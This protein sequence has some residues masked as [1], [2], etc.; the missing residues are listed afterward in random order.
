MTDIIL[1]LFLIAACA[2]CCWYW[3]RIE[4]A[5]R[6]EAEDNSASAEPV[7]DLESKK[8][9]VAAAM[10][11]INVQGA[12]DGDKD[13]ATM[14]FDYQGGHF[15]LE[16][17]SGNPDA[18]LVFPF[19]YSLSIKDV[20]ALRTF[21]NRINQSFTLARLV[22]SCN[23]QT[24][25]AD[26]H[27][28]SGFLV[29][30]R[31]AGAAVA[32][33]LNEM[34][35]CRNQVYGDIEEVKR[36]NRK[37]DYED[38][39]ESV[40]ISDY[41][42]NLMAESELQLAQWPAAK[43][44]GG[45]DRPRLGRVLGS[46]LDFDAS[47]IQSM[48]VMRGDG[49]TAVVATTPAADS[50]STDAEDAAKAA[51]QAIADFDLTTAMVADGR[52]MG[53]N[54]MIAVTYLANPKD[55]KPRLLTLSLSPDRATDEALYMR[56]TLTMEAPAV[57]PTFTLGSNETRATAR[58]FCIACDLVPEAHIAAKFSY[59]WKEAM[60][61]DCDDS[62]L[63]DDDRR[64]LNMLRQ[65]C[66]R[67]NAY[68]VYRGMQLF[69]QKRYAEALPR[70]RSAYDVVKMHV[71]PSDKVEA[72]NMLDLCYSI[73]VAYYVL[74]RYAQ[75]A[76]YLGLTVGL[77]NITYLKAYVNA[78]IME[79]DVRAD[80][81][82]SSELK[83]VGDE[84]EQERASDDDDDDSGYSDRAIQ[85][86]GYMA[87]LQCRKALLLASADR[88]DEAEELLHQVVNS[89]D[90]KQAVDTLAMVRRMR[91]ARDRR[92]GDDKQA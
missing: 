13:E 5:H 67:S 56:A 32:S 34:F 22:Y 37:A 29:T 73:G 61:D 91:E 54:A 16:L 36:W 6:L 31:L 30:E 48:T 7:A 38:V 26:L 46:V 49:T 23:S 87:F 85:L 65:S 40:V 3:V 82:V 9:L 24:A 81:F 18:R 78:I 8:A 51:S 79:R 70:L 53:G 77:R 12:W 45:D 10:Q 28:I 57:L 89:P 60:A 62:K 55:K 25:Q 58:T 71:R 14:H 83:Q 4:R 11:D 68:D 52:F 84:L 50:G 41:E 21:I 75:A 44:Y 47:S 35:A 72:W 20:S 88:F 15:Y 2:A 1:G 69:L 74:G 27:I 80:A 39:E 64:F 42:A 17:A 43:H 19:F 90:N 92:R 86:S 33:C 59:L 76:Y 66:D 63:S